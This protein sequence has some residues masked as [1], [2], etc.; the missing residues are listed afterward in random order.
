MQPLTTHASSILMKIKIAAHECSQK[1]LL[2]YFG[3][4]QYFT[5][6]RAARLCVIHVLKKD[7]RFIKQSLYVNLY[8]LLIPPVAIFICSLSVCVLF[9][10]FTY[11]YS[12][13]RF[14]PKKRATIGDPKKK[15][16]LA[17]QF[18]HLLHRNTTSSKKL[19]KG[20]SVYCKNSF[21]YRAML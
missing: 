10:V 5:L 15:R 21:V 18:R 2:R 19:G 1:R 11:C 12:V 14:W 17:R 3:M 7:L 8:I 13:V 9:Y 6:P 20:W 4:K 16:T